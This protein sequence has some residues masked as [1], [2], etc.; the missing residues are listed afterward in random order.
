MA[1]AWLGDLS[2]QRKPERQELTSGP[3]MRAEERYQHGR[4][5][6]SNQENP[7][8]CSHTSRPPLHTSQR[9]LQ[10]TIAEI[11]C[12]TTQTECCNFL[13]EIL[14]PQETFPLTRDTGR[15][16]FFVQCTCRQLQR[17][18]ERLRSGWRGKGRKLRVPPPPFPARSTSPC[19]MKEV[20]GITWR[21]RDGEGPK[22]ETQNEQ[23][24]QGRIIQLQNQRATEDEAAGWHHRLDGHEFQ[25]A[26]GAGGGQ[27][28]PACCSPWGRKESDMT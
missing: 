5:R 7:R 25:Q 19:G 8:S 18:G 26:S 10:N 22:P 17:T 13:L 9:D 6:E 4:I 3:C 11:L 21:H 1:S 20:P 24:R 16:I 28:S 15:I 12:N 23:G 2:H 27:G 14:P